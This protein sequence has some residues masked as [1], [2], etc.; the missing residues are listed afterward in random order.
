MLFIAGIVRNAQV[1]SRARVCMCVCVCVYV[2][3]M[4]ALYCGTWQHI[5]YGSNP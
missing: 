5:W 1:D 2:C 4:Q 3:E